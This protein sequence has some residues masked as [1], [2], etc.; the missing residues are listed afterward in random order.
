M[1]RTTVMPNLNFPL[2]SSTSL[3]SCCATSPLMGT[4]LLVP[5]ATVLLGSFRLA[6]SSLYRME[7]S[8]WS[9]RCPIGPGKRPAGGHVR[10][11]SIPDGPAQPNRLDL[12]GAARRRY[13][14]SELPLFNQLAIHLFFAPGM[15]LMRFNSIQSASPRPVSQFHESGSAR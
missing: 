6:P 5:P 15:A 4:S 13:A 11:R 2:L 1:L 3:C 10:S 14:Q 12:W 9:G 8:V 7:C